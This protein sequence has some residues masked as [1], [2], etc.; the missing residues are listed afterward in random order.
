[1]F[2]TKQRA[3]MG[4]VFRDASAEAQRRGDTRV[5]TE[6]FVLAVLVDPDSDTA[7]ALGVTLAEARDALQ[8]LDNAALASV[9][10]DA[11]DPGPRTVTRARIRVT[12]GVRNIFVGL[13]FD[14]TAKPLLGRHVLLGLL[15]LTPP[16][17]AAE[18]LDALQINRAEVREHL[19]AP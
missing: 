13:R 19:L 11:V 15:T 16:D 4:K 18:L 3:A 14:S 5:G 8:S 7:R 6:H 1:M 12:P 9:G 17:P 2:G 10:I